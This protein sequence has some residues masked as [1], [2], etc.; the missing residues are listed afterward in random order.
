MKLT[1]MIIAVLFLMACQLITADDPIDK[2]ENRAT[3]LRDIMRRPKDY[4]ARAHLPCK[5]LNESCPSHREC[6][7]GLQCCGYKGGSCMINDPGC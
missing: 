2:Q 5:Q 4:G 1:C 6:C 3:R 7:P